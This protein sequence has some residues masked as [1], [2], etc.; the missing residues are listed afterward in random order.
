MITITCRQSRPPVHSLGHA[1][2]L[3]LAAV[4][5]C[6]VWQPCVP[7][8]TDISGHF[9]ECMNQELPVARYQ[10]VILGV[11]EGIGSCKCLILIW[12]PPRDSN[13]DMLIQRQETLD[14][15]EFPAVLPISQE[16]PFFVGFSDDSQKRVTPSVN[17]RQLKKIS[18]KTKHGTDFWY[19]LCL[20]NA[21]TV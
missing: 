8:N 13:P 17:I 7:I 10:S 3:G 5:I 1:S 11:F 21:D 16:I 18:Q 14:S 4:I 20:A 15:V 12:L 6:R 9:R 2:M 19:R